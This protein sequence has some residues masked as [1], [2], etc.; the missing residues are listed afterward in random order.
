MAILRLIAHGESN[1]AIAYQ[2][3]ISQHTV[4]AHARNIMQKLE[5]ANRVQ[6]AAVAFRAGLAAS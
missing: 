3:S 5:V 2:L 4:R 6:A 1:K